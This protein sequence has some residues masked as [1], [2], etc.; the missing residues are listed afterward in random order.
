MYWSYF[1][2]AVFYQFEGIVPDL[3][4]CT[5]PTAAGG[6]GGGGGVSNS[7]TLASSRQN[8]ASPKYNDDISLLIL[9]YTCII[10]DFRCWKLTN[11]ALWQVINIGGYTVR[12]RPVHVQIAP[13]HVQNRPKVQ[14][15]RTI[16]TVHIIRPKCTICTIL[17]PFSSS[18]AYVQI[19]KF[20]TRQ[21]HI[22]LFESPT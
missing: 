17:P 18:T 12:G 3:S 16:L 5:L 11:S 4:Q 7:G 10:S 2:L 9:Q 15:V 20:N 19:L 21:L 22:S 13:V 14:N 8:S 6:G 1:G